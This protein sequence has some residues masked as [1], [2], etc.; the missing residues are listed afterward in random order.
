MD[1]V[2]HS[3]RPSFHRGFDNNKTKPRDSYPFFL[4]PEILYVISKSPLKISM[5]DEKAT[6]FWKTVSSINWVTTP[7]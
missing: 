7:T 4:F 2:L 6:I 5:G 1:K 3:M